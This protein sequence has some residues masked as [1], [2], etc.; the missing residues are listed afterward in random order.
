MG[1]KE[2]RRFY[3]PCN[4]IEQVEAKLRSMKMVMP[5]LTRWREKNGSN[6]FGLIFQSWGP[7]VKGKVAG[8]VVHF[9]YCPFCGS[10]FKD[11]RVVLTDGVNGEDRKD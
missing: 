7:P 11:D 4:C 5:G 2:T 1:N 9:A 6:G 10:S 8:G 3:L